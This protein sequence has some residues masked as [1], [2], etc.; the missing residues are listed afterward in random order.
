MIPKETIIKDIIISPREIHFLRFIIE[1]YEGIGVV[2]TLDA[3][4]GLVRL[5]IAPGCEKEV[6][7]I[8]EA[9]KDHLQIRPFTPD[10]APLRRV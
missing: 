4:L 5:S 2:S 6:D 8:L 7:L 10:E 3:R 9:E 1:A